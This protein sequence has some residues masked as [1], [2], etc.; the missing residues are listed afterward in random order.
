M[1]DIAEACGTERTE[2]SRAFYE[3]AKGKKQEKGEFK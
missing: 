2:K 3:N 1:L